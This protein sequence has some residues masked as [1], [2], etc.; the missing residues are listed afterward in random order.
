MQFKGE[1]ID[2]RK[3][4]SGLD[5]DELLMLGNRAFD[6]VLV[7]GNQA[8]AWHDSLHKVP[9]IEDNFKCITYDALDQGI[10]APNRFNE[11]QSAYAEE[12]EL[13]KGKNGTLYQF[14]GAITR[15]NRD[16]NLFTIDNRT[17]KL[18]DLCD[19]YRKVV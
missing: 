12:L 5:F 10:L 13:V 4:T 14:H 6:Q 2:F 16:L 19:Q 15:M 8:I 9:L 11:F 18:A 1:F 7:Q 3:H 17:R